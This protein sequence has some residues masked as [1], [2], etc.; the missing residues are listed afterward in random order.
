MFL[1]GNRETR[2]TQRL[3]LSTC[4]Y[5]FKYLQYEL[6]KKNFNFI[7]CRQIT[8]ICTLKQLYE[9]LI[10][11]FYFSFFSK[12]LSNCLTSP[13][14]LGSLFKKSERKFQMYVVYCQNK[15]K[16]EHIVSDYIDTYFEVRD[17]FNNIE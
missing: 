7:L 6:T 14:D 12:N 17:Y 13:G 15:P 1:A 3:L 10:L 5:G 11:I 16:S 4:F 2:K 8:S 9:I